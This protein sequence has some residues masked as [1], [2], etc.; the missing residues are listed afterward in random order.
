M[1]EH[2]GPT[3]AEVDQKAVVAGDRFI[4]AVAPMLAVSVTASIKDWSSSS[5]KVLL[6]RCSF[7][8]GILHS[9]MP[10][11]PTPARLK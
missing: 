7:L 3:V 4:N 10:L 8:D 2:A 9:M 1:A 6:V 5:N 11:V